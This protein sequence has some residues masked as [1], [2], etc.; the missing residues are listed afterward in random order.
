MLVN[1]AL[2][3]KCG[4]VVQ[5]I[6]NWRFF[7]QYAY[8]TPC[9]WHAY[10]QTILCIGLVLYVD[11]VWRKSRPASHWSI[12]KPRCMGWIV[13]GGASGIQVVRTSICGR[14][15]CC[16]SLFILKIIYIDPDNFD[17][18]C[19]SWYASSETIPSDCFRNAYLWRSKAGNIAKLIYLANR[20]QNHRNVSRPQLCNI[21]SRHAWGNA[22]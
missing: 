11:R 13:A 9:A 18:F 14:P 20:L 7:A 5:H 10:A 12:P 16:G 15:S 22:I 3:R 19:R 6:S 1:L 21:L 8:C 4:I 2:Y 17:Q